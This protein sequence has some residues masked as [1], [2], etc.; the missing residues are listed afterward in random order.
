MNDQQAHALLAEIYLKAKVIQNG[1]FWTTVNAF[2]DQT[3]A[4]P[5]KTLTEIG[6]AMAR[7]IDPATT[8]ILIEEDKGAHIAT[9]VSL[10]TGIPLVLARHCRRIAPRPTKTIAASVALG[11]GRAEKLL[12]NRTLP[13]SPCRRL[14]KIHQ[15]NLEIRSQLRYFQVWLSLAASRGRQAKTLTAI[16][17]RQQFS[18]EDF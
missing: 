17:P 14:A 3:E 18:Y 9:T 2:T 16:K 6:W 11:G 8:I 7:R 5:P 12:G 4:L 10:L 1:Q 15:W 13:A